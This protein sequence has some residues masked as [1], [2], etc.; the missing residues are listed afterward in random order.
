MVELSLERLFPLGRVLAT[1]GA[2]D[3]LDRTG[4]NADDLLR[5][6]LGGD[7][8]VV[9]SADARTNNLAVVNGTRILSA[10]E[11][12]TRREKLWVLTEADRRATTLLLPCEY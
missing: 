1:P 7:W 10:Y 4:T 12:G 8:G 3:L 11:L 9:S 2:I 5:R 6:H